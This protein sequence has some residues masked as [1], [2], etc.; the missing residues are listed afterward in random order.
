M[1]Q[2]VYHKTYSGTPQGSG[3]S[4]LL[5]NIVLNELDSFIEDELLP[6][7]NRGKARRFNREYIRLSKLEQR[8]KKRGDWNTASP[9]YTDTPR[10][11]PNHFINRNELVTRLLTANGRKDKERT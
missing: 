9:S 1:E 3:L 11:H 2:W 6:Q 8:A 5:A 4:P 10:R 7:Y